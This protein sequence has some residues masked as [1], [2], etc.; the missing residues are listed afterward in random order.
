MRMNNTRFGS[1]LIKE[2]PAQLEV[3]GW[4]KH[5]MKMYQEKHG[6]LEGAVEP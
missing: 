6:S 4:S 3:H 5:K 1:K 2:E